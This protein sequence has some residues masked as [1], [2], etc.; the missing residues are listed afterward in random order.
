MNRIKRILCLV[1][2]FALMM[3][4]TSFAN[5][6]TWEN[7]PGHHDQSILLGSEYLFAEDAVHQYARGEMLAE[8]SVKITN[9]KNG[10]I[11]VTITTLAYHNVDAIYHTAFLDEWSDSANDWV[12]VGEWS[13]ERTKEEANND[14]HRLSTSFT[15]TGY[16]TN[17]YYRVRGLHS[18]ELGGDTEGCSTETNGVLITSK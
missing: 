2:V 4:G 8:G 16:D 9:N 1:I 13:F 18:V 10:T 14:L 15:L 6:L 11:G 5:P 3:S 7:A 12:N 17:K